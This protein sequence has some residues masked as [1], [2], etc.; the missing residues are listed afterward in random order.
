MFLLVNILLTAQIISG[1][2]SVG[3][4][5]GVIDPTTTTGDMIWR[6]SGGALDRLGAGANGAILSYSTVGPGPAWVLTTGLNTTG[7]AATAST[8]LTAGTTFSI[9]GCSATSATGSSTA[10]TLVSGTTGACTVVITMGASLTATTGWACAVS[11]RTTANL[12]RQSAS[13]TT[14]ATLTGTTNS[15]DVLS[16]FCVG[17]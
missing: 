14:T 17:Y 12:F 1:G 6:N 9:S 2:A 8:L 7:N 4:G 11:N 15:S 5:G 13:S 16:F 3:G 10:G